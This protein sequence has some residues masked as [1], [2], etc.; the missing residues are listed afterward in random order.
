MP[1]FSGFV[2]KTVVPILRPYK[3]KL[4]ESHAIPKNCPIYFSMIKKMPLNILQQKTTDIHTDW[5]QQRSVKSLVCLFFF[6]PFPP[7][8]NCILTIALKKQIYTKLF[9][10][11][12]LDLVWGLRSL[13]FT[14]TWPKRQ[15]KIMKIENVKRKHGKIQGSRI[16]KQKE[17]R[18]VVELSVTLVNKSHGSAGFWTFYEGQCTKKIGHLTFRSK[19]QQIKV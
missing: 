15:L 5:F 12:N 7:F 3:I 14:A 19:R 6:C 13:Q 1:K 18:G 4:L 16:Q 2:T 17:E 8:K 9:I 11:Q 10:F